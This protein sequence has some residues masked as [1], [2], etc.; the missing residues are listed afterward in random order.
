[1]I[2]KGMKSNLPFMNMGSFGRC[3]P[4]SFVPHRWC[5]S[6]A[7]IKQPDIAP[8]TRDP[9]KINNKNH[10]HTQYVCDNTH[11]TVTFVLQ[12]STKIFWYFV[13]QKWS[14]PD[15]FQK[16]MLMSFLFGSAWKPDRRPVRAQPFESLTFHVPRVVRKRRSPPVLDPVDPVIVQSFGLFWRF[17]LP[18][19]TPPEN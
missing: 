9:H 18:T 10:T 13:V 12:I 5:W 19:N 3:V 15:L 17:E 1:M 11:F 4:V 14:F 8:F 16:N 7:H 2:F 6:W